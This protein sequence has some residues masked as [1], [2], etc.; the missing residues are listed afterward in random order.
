MILK[1]LKYVDKDLLIQNGSIAVDGERIVGF[2]CVGSDEFD[3]SGLTALPGFIDIHTH[4]GSG[5]D[6]CDKS[7]Q[8]LCTLSEHYARHGVTSFCP[9][10]MTLPFDEL[11][12]IFTSIEQYKGREAAAYIQGINMEGP[13]VSPK[14]CGAQNTDFIRAADK[15]EFYKLN[16]ISKISLVDLAPETENAISFAR[17]ISNHTVCSVAHTDATYEETKASFQSGFTH[18][19]HFFNAMT[20]LNHREP[21]VVG[22]VFENNSVTAEL[23]CDGFH[24]NEAAVRLA[25]KVLG[26]NRCVAISDSL[27]SA[28]CADGEYMLGGQ[29][30]IVKNGKAHLENGTIAGSTANLFDEFKNLLSFGIPFESALKACTINPAR[31]IGVDSIC[32]SIEIGK[33][34]DI[35]FVDSSMNLK[36]V[37]IK[38]R[39][40]W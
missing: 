31:V 14:K 25:F 3:M 30:V 5:A 13:Y 26:D 6:A 15:D 10:T 21:G 23:I 34:A 1:N 35:I 18:V 7:E 24:L 38:G 19:T 29:K 36:H 9:T 16:S 39:M 17:E 27:N 37:M 28:D 4:G 2:D 22:A 11:C 12:D 32:G 40:I 8:S 20:A 33:R